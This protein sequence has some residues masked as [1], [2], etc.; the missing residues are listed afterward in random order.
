MTLYYLKLYLAAF[1][2]FLAIDM[3]W[4]V[5]VARS[6][7]RKH[8][9]DLLADQPNWWA[10][11]TFYLLFIVGLLV[12][13]VIPALNAGSWRNAAAARQ[14][15]RA[16]DVCNLRSD[17]SGNRQELALGRDARRHDVG[18]GPLRLSQLH[19]LRRRTLAAVTHYGFSGVK[20][21]LR[22]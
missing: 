3:V 4:L 12:F 21:T 13:A 7:Y 22:N 2:G 17:Q 9:G 10:A 5:I 6:F 19:R 15:L 11:I 16:G 18:R 1:A 14:F 8:L 20:R